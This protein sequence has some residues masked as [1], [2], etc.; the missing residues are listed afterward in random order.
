MQSDSLYYTI[1]VQR[2]TGVMVILCILSTPHIHI[3]YE[4]C[5]HLQF[6]QYSAPVSIGLTDDFQPFLFNHLEMA[7]QI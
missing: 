3:Y 7:D 6:T 2:S 1:S 4:F 5:P